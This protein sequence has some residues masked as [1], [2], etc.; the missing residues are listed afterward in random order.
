MAKF[1]STNYKPEKKQVQFFQNF[2]STEAN[3]IPT[4]LA[5]YVHGV[6][7]DLRRLE[8]DD[9]DFNQPLLQMHSHNLTINRLEV[10]PC[11]W[12][13][14]TKYRDVYRYFLPQQT[15]RFR[16]FG[17]LYPNVRRAIFRQCSKKKSPMDPNAVYQFLNS[18]RN[19]MTLDF[20]KTRLDTKFYNLLPFID[21][22]RFVKIIF[23]FE[24]ENFHHMIQ[25]D[26]L[27][28]F[29]F[30][31]HFQTNTAIKEMMLDV[32]DGI[33]RSGQKMI[34]HFCGHPNFEAS[35]ANPNTEPKRRIKYFFD[36]SDESRQ[37]WNFAFKQF[38]MDEHD[39]RMDWSGLQFDTT[40]MN[41]LIESLFSGHSVTPHWIKFD[42]EQYLRSLQVR[43]E[44]DWIA[45]HLLYE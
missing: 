8:F 42:K 31:Q 45:F 29:R 30:L 2:Y 18:C 41:E 44:R 22:C 24:D 32:L 1:T 10:R 4:G 17:N 23:I 9:Y 3:R 11:R 38:E 33:T 5:I 37:S 15:D 35:E 40:T 20:Y 28:K 36:K 39:N 6:L 43:E 16:R 19:W 34:F 27:T 7:L 14:R 25:F 26:F 13:A 21:S 12:V